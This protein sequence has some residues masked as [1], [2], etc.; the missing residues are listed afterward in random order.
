MGEEHNTEQNQHPRTSKPQ[1]GATKDRREKMYKVTKE[2]GVVATHARHTGT[3]E[4]EEA[5]GNRRGEDE[6][7][8]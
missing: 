7:R 8:H 1:C 5:S 2:E 6:N 4:R 3:K